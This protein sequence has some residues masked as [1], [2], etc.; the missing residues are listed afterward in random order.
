MFDFLD[1]DIFVIVLNIAFLI[2]IIYDYKKYQATKQKM[3]L[4]NIALTIGFAIWVMVPFYNKYFTWDESHI[5]K[6]TL[7]CSEANETLRDCI[8]DTTIKS[9][10]LES[11]QSEDKNSSD[12]QEFLQEC[13]KEC[14]D[15]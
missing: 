14:L 1:N 2:F 7:E 10:T 4:F 5:H 8:V 15:K 3:L 6:L 9:Y 11:F 13:R 12:Y